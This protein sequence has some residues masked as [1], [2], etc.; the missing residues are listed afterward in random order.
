MQCY[1][2]AHV[3]PAQKGMHGDERTLKGVIIME[4]DNRPWG[5]YEVLA[6]K[7]EYKAKRIIVYPGKRLSLQRHR[8]RSEHWFILCGRAV[9]T[10]D[11]EE[12]DLQAGQSV[13]IPLGAA[14]RI[15]NAGDENL[16]FIEIQTGT[17]FGEDDIE[18]FQD[19]FGRV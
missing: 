8:R 14:H 5:Y 3:I 9:V 7:V 6:D 2:T 17:Y 10:I 12:F 18:R 4:M 15:L 13:D 11:L 16:A 1:E 19:D